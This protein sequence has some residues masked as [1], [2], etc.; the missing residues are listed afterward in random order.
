M[1][2]LLPSSQP[3]LIL[4]VWT[5]YNFYKL[6][7]FPCRGTRKI[8]HRIS[9]FPAHFCIF[10]REKTMKIHIKW[11]Y[12]IEV[13]ILLLKALHKITNKSTQSFTFHISTWCYSLC[14]RNQFDL[15][16][17]D[18]SCLSNSESVNSF[19]NKL[20]MTL[21]QMQPAAKTPHVLDLLCIC[22]SFFT[23]KPEHMPRLRSKRWSYTPHA[24]I[25]MKGKLG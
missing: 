20:P 10:H 9:K 1:L 24:L 19:V 16:H 12:L 18:N 13:G 8:R 22:F 11:L 6:R 23:H 17:N 4:Y 21:P 7:T 2:A 15:Q 3:T 5:T 25:T 14:W